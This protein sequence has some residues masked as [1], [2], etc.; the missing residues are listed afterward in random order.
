[1]ALYRATSQA[2]IQ[3]QKMGRAFDYLFNLCHST[4]GSWFNSIRLAHLNQYYYIFY[5]LQCLSPVFRAD[6]NWR[7]LAFHFIL[8]RRLARLAVL[9]KMASSLVVSI[10]T[11][12]SFIPPILSLIGRSTDLACYILDTRAICS[13]LQVLK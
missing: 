5:R 2:I 4:I 11:I 3:V 1:M 13:A 12:L 9:H 7:A 6:S 8:L 10:D